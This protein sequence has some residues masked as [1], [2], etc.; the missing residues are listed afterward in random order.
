VLRLGKVKASFI[1]ILHAKRLKSH[2]YVTSFSPFFTT[3]VRSSEIKNE[4]VHFILLS[5]C[6]SAYG[7]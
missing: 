5:A 7:E 4:Q 3:K 6:T 1:F 2:F